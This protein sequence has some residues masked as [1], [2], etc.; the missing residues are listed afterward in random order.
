[1]NSNNKEEVFVNIGEYQV[2][3]GENKILKIVGI[4]SCVCVILLDN[5]E[6]V[7]G[8][9][10][11]MLPSSKMAKSNVN[12]KKFADTGIKMM[13]EDMKNL[14][15]KF[16]E[17]VI[18]GGACMFES[19]V[20]DPLM[21]IGDRNVEMTKEVLKEEKIPVVK[22]DVGGNFGRTVIFDTS[23]NTILVS[24]YKQGLKKL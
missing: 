4:G 10:H 22:E 18:I 16:F 9:A 2:V 1:M 24:S 12:L 14:G 20:N 23:T 6:K 17:A 5:K 11:I 7:Y 19:Q 3:K 15:A 13:I 21:K 8:M